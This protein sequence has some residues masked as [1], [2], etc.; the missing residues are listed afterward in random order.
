[1][2]AFIIALVYIMALVVSVF[3][4]AV[5][6]TTVWNIFKTRHE[7]EA[8]PDSPLARHQHNPIMEPDCT[9]VWEADA[10]FNPAAFFYRGRT[11]LFYRALG[12][13]GASRVGYASSEDGVCFTQRLKHPVFT[14]YNRN[15]QPYPYFMRRYRPDLYSS[16]GGWG[17]CEDPRAVVIDERIYLTFSAFDGWDSMRIGIT[18]LPL[19]HFTRKWWNWSA[20]LYLSP[21]H[22]VHK[23]WVLFP[24]KINGQFALMTSI[25][26]EI[27]IAYADTIEDFA[28]NP[29]QSTFTQKKNW[30]HWEER[31]RGAGPPPI[32]TDAGWLVLYHAHDKDSPDRYQLGAMLLDLHNPTK[33]IARAP[34][35]ILHPTSWYEN[36]GKPGVVYATG[37]VV[38]DD[39]LY[40]YYG[41]ADRVVCVAHTP[42]DE[43][44]AFITHQKKPAVTTQPMLR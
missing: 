9:N 18:S 43:L 23:N 39:L 41:G 17:G 19:S 40:I 5:L 24:E 44:I 34:A 7:E 4:V 8:A 13:E 25:T 12:P 14:Y 20:P 31:V 38:R 42:L 35:P 21:E 33:V 1:M 29:P 28:K 10:V 2:T 11:H 37:A 32:K 15:V 6:A 26:P 36:E 27:H 3:I 16:G 30:G 22:E